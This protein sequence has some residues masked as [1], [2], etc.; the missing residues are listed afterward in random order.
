MSERPEIRTLEE[1]LGRPLDRS[2]EGS[3][4]NL[5]ELPA[6]LVADARALGDRGLGRELLRFYVAPRERAFL[7]LFLQD[8][9]FGGAEASQWQRGRVLVPDVGLEAL[10]T[11]RPEDLLQAIGGV[12]AVRIAPNEK[13]W[14][15]G[16][17]WLGAPARPEPQADH[18]TPIPRGVVGL[19]HPATDP[20]LDPDIALRRWIAARIAMYLRAKE[21]L[22]P[23][24]VHRADL[25]W[26]WRWS[27][28]ARV[29]ERALMR[30][31]RELGPAGIPG[32]RGPDEW[33]GG[34][35]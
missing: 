11:K 1:R 8:V 19:V 32:F 12:A 30:E 21:A 2:R 24:G 13:D 15:S 29:A 3:V 6:D 10:L 7:E 5:T 4:A 34:A 16:A 14:E 28:N 20:I 31:V 17:P 9:V 33:Y 23:A 22:P 26:R 18:R 25:P 27:R 35:P